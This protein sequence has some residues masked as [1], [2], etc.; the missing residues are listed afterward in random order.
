MSYTFP[1]MM[2][3]ID[4]NFQ[5]NQFEIDTCWNSH[6]GVFVLHPH[7]GDNASQREKF[8]QDLQAKILEVEQD[9]TANNGIHPRSSVS[10]ASDL[11]SKLT[12][13]ATAYIAVYPV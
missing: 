2:S 10:Y 6:N 8:K 11:T 12:F 3:E 4:P 7:I 1:Q 13:P 5:Y 9:Y